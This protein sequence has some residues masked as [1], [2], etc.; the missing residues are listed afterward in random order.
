MIRNCKTL[1]ISLPNLHLNNF[2]ASGGEREL[3]RILDAD[4]ID[5]PYEAFLEGL[6]GLLL[7]S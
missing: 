6:I 5:H 3:S 1:K 7:V 2:A 4:G